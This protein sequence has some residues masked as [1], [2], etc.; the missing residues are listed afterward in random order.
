[1]SIKLKNKKDSKPNLSTSIFNIK[2]KF[3]FLEISS[4]ITKKRLLKLSLRS[5]KFQYYTNITIEDYEVYNILQKNEYKNINL[6]DRSIESSSL[7]LNSIFELSKTNVL[8]NIHTEINVPTVIYAITQLENKKIIASTENSL[9]EIS[10]DEN[11]NKFNIINEIPIE[12]KSVVCHIIELKNNLLLLGDFLKNICILNLD[13]KKITYEIFGNCPI[14]LNDGKLSFIF[15]EKFIKICNINSVN[16][17]SD[18]IEIK[19]DKNNNSIDKIVVSYGI[20]LKNNNILISLWDKTLSEY[21]ICTKTCVNFIKTECDFIHFLL[22]LKDERI[23]FTSEDNARIYIIQKKN[24][25]KI[26]VLNGHTNTVIKAIENNNGNII[27]ASCDGTIKFWEK[28]SNGNFN[29]S[30]TVLISN[31]YIR[32]LVWMNDG[33]ILISTDEKKLIAVGFKNYFGNFVLK[34]LPDDRNKNINKS[35]QI[36][37][38]CIK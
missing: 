24:N 31:D 6:N 1:M 17:E 23:L 27:S 29:C 5:K 22:E 32:N 35:F 34:Y 21:E 3:I 16:S 26:L 19:T 4:F 2:S 30:M 8:N 18:L 9:L 10:Y 36:I 12:L 14:L 13:N 20:Q 11:N 38:N 7:L 37:D 15:E 25:N 33:R 28:I